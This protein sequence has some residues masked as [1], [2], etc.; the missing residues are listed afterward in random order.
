MEFV[1]ILIMQTI[2]VICSLGVTLVLAIIYDAFGG[3]LRWFSNIWLVGMIYYCPS[4]ITLI[5]S[6]MVFLWWKQRIVRSNVYVLTLSVFVQMCLHAQC[7]ILI[8]LSW[9]LTGF[10]IKSAF[11]VVM[12][13]TF[14]GLSMFVNMVF[15]MF[16]CGE[17]ISR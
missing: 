14:Y 15:K 10:E 12:I 9:F 4:A 3:S 13:V 6:P 1:R 16:L 17:L 2:S 8:V 5:L 11:M 7:V